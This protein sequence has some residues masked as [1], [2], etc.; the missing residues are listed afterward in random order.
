[1]EFG[2]LKQIEGVDFNLPPDDP[3]NDRLWR[4]L[5]PV[6]RRPLELFVGCARWGVKEWVGKVYPKGTKD[7]DFLA[8]YAKQFNCIELNSLFYGLQP[9]QVIQQW[10]AATPDGFRFCPKFSNTISHERQLYQAETDTGLF[11]D[12]MR[13]FGSR[14]G[15]SFLQLSD[16]FGPDRAGVL[17]DYLKRLPSDFPVCVELRR[18]DW[19][20]R[21]ASGGAR[22]SAVWDQMQE[23]GIGTVITDTAGRRDVVHMRLTAPFVFIRCVCVGDHPTNLARLDAWV[24]RIKMWMDKGLQE[25]YF[26]VHNNEEI[27]TPMLVAYAIEQFN[28]KCGTSLAPPKKMAVYQPGENLSLF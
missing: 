18:E 23:L 25:V 14:L 21:R 3:G 24:D 4:Q 28:K 16:G 8:E 17:G 6:S 20:V 26:I 2:K 10:A 15:T 19:F 22:I 13:Y 5:Q 9:P 7:K 12:H 1:M 11:I 27:Y